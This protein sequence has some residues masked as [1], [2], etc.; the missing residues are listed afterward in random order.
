MILNMKRKENNVELDSIRFNKIRCGDSR[1]KMKK[2]IRLN[3]EGMHLRKY[4]AK[5]RTYRMK[6]GSLYDSY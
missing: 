5:T 6:D 3:K 4:K 2:K 1:K